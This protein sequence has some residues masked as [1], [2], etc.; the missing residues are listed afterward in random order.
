MHC[1]G[2][3]PRGYA[4]GGRVSGSKMKKNCP[5]YEVRKTS[6]GVDRIYNGD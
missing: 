1:G 5:S 3:V 2:Y 4:K 6:N